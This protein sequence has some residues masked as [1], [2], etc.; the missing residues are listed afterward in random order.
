MSIIAW[1]IVS[2]ILTNRIRYSRS[3][4]IWY[5][6]SYFIYWLLYAFIFLVCISYSLHT[7]E[8]LYFAMAT[9]QEITHLLYIN[10]LQ[11]FTWTEG[12]ADPTYIYIYLYINLFFLT[13]ICSYTTSTKYKY[14]HFVEK[15]V[16]NHFK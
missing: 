4:Y 3:L 8:R 1:Y 2:L 13:N 16:H 15:Q 5:I 6:Y 10:S 14:N 7:R 12:S 11:H 9:V